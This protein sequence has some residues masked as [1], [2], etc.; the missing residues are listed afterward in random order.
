[1]EEPLSMK[2]ILKK[3]GRGAQVRKPVGELEAESDKSKNQEEQEEGRKRRQ[4]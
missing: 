2:V 3:V 1:M 4:G